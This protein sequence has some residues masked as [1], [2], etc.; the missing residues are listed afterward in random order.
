MLGILLWLS[1]ADLQFWEVW[2][3]DHAWTSGRWNISSKREE[4]GK[5][6]ST[7]LQCR[8]W[9]SCAKTSRTSELGQ[10][11]Q[12]LNNLLNLSINLHLLSSQDPPIQRIYQKGIWKNAS[13]LLSLRGVLNCIKH[14]VNVPCIFYKNKLW[15][16]FAEW[17]LLPPIT[18][19]GR[20]KGF[21]K[22]LN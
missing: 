12:L 8:R 13:W 1:S 6:R 17:E 15:L 18:G 5:S 2:G 20:T 7:C 19:R 9:T 16:S 22:S 21:T 11:H 4:K 10:S 14:V 3:W